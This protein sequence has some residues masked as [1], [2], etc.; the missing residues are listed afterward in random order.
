MPK[1]ERQ[2]VRRC[3]SGD[4]NAFGALYDAHASRVFSLLCRLIGDP[5]ESE[6]LTQET[7]LAAYSA[8]GSWR[9]EGA[10]STWLCGIAF[11][12]YAN[13]QRRRA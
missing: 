3:L 10:F 2:L 5:A 11:R 13:A 7:F 9:G 6:D 1:D 8:L 4:H 12:L